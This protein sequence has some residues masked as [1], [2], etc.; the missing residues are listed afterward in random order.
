MH[1]L[2]W[3][4]GQQYEF[5]AKDIHPLRAASCHVII[6]NTSNQKSFA[7]YQCLLNHL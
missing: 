4:F 7:N 3:H 5:L 2:L 6:N 1:V